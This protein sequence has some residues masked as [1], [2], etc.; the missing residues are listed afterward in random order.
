MVYERI[1]LKECKYNSAIRVRIY[2]STKQM[3]IIKLNSDVSRFAYN[4]YVAL[5]KERYKINTTLKE[6]NLTN[7]EVV[8][9][10]NRLEQIKQLNYNPSN[11]NIVHKWLTLDKNIDPQTKY[12]AS[13]AY[14]DAWNMFRKIPK[15]NP[16]TFKKRSHIQKYST[17][18]CFILDKKHIRIN[19]IGKIRT[20]G[21]NLNKIHNEIYIG[22]TTIT[23]ESDGKYYL[24]VTIAS[25]EP[26]ASSEKTGSIV[27]IDLNLSNFLVDSNGEVIDNP[28]YAKKMRKKLAKEQR[29]LSRKY[30]AAKKENRKL[31]D[32]IN[33]QKQRIKVAELHKRISNQREYFQH[34]LST[35]I[36]KS[37]DY[38][39]AED[40]KPSN[41]NKNKKLSRAIADAGWSQFLGMLEYKA[42]QHDK[43]F[44]KVDPRYTTQTCSS[45]SHVMSGLDKIKLG[46]EEWLCPNCGVH[47]DRDMNA[48]INIMNKG[49]ELMK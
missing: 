26:F 44:I 35:E 25:K 7:N 30:Q 12:M 17:S 13:K 27:G 22:K 48:A 18:E 37:H 11:L 45:C 4:E 43:V 1:V 8:E 42:L 28:K 31:E 15:T 9:L 19:K 5:G 39:F 38:I 40:I 2:P 23:K 14:K 10:K 34:K 32:S 6:N 20:S 33:Y 49:L 3:Q 41:L 16:P 36:I 21:L 29:S 47:H 24:S 46:I